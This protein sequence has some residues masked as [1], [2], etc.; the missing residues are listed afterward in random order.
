VYHTNVILCIGHQFAVLCTETIRDEQERKKVIDSLTGTG[1]E[2]IDITQEQLK[3]YAGNMLEVKNQ[4]G[5]HF[6]VMSE[7]AF[8]SLRPDQVQTIRK[9]AEIL[10]PP[11]YTIEHI[12]GGSARC[13]MQKYFYPQSKKKTIIH[14]GTRFQKREDRELLPFPLFFAL[15]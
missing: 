12:G 11:I 15:L 13:M 6:L 3:Q 2:V 1:H 7:Q 4:T 9:Y 14:K 5:Q 8:Q 10:A